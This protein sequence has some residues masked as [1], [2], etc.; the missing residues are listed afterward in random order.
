MDE[1]GRVFFCF[2]YCL[3]FDYSHGQ[4]ALACQ[5]KERSLDHALVNI[6][7]CCMREHAAIGT[8]LMSISHNSPKMP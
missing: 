8:D 4:D 6:P 3:V 5:R 7:V 2:G 1:G